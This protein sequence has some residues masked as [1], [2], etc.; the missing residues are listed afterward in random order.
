LIF[1]YVFGIKVAGSN[2]SSPVL[3]VVEL[4]SPR[5]L[6][7]PGLRSGVF[8]GYIL[9]SQQSPSSQKTLTGNVF[10]WFEFWFRCIGFNYSACKTNLSGLGLGL[11]E[12]HAE[13]AETGWTLFWAA[14]SMRYLYSVEN[15]VASFLKTRV[16]RDAA[17]ASMLGWNRRVG[18]WRSGHSGTDPFNF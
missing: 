1:L 13:M 2:S 5:P 10:Q 17:A 15:F 9:F 8:H 3:R 16:Q 14:L 12:L 11:V 6:L 18:Y 7:S 4:D